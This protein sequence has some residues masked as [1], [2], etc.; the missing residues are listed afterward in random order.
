M[1]LTEFWGRMEHQ[2]GVGYASSV[3]SDQVLSELGG[4]T[5]AEALDAGDDPK[6]VWR[7]VCA[8]FD[9]PARER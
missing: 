6:V 4:R 2:F 1:R 5:V 8:A 3:A 9:V 7:G